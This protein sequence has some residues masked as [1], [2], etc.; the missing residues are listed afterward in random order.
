[1]WSLRASI[2][3]DVFNKTVKQETV[4]VG[5]VVKVLPDS[6][7]FAELKVLYPEIHSFGLNRMVI[8]HADTLKNDIVN[9]A[10]VHFKTGIKN[11]DQVKLESWLRVRYQSPNLKLVIEK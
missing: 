11:V 6:A 5:S 8:R 10:L 3:E 1:M 2:L 4:K 7:I 9:V